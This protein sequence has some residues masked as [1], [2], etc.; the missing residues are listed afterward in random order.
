MKEPRRTLA[1]ALLV[2]AVAL[3][4]G[5]AANALNP[6]GLAIRRD[7]FR[8]AEPAPASSQPASPDSIESVPPAHSESAASEAA[9]PAFADAQEAATAERLRER[10]LQ[11][12]T[13]AQAVAA[14]E[15]PMYAAGGSLFVD[16]RK[17]EEYEQGHVPGAW[18]L[19]HY[20]LER[21]LDE[22]LA[23]ARDALQIVVYCNGKDCEDSELAAL[24]LIGFGVDPSR[25][26]VYVGGWEAWRAAGLPVETGPRGARP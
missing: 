18:P 4:L 17:D 7:Y 21:H 24:D 19:D 23:V 10:D 26:A 9:P 14:F 8:T 2:G 3:G 22:V 12:W 13:H 25:V 1:E 5:F 16:A 11:P 15:D 6:D 20:H